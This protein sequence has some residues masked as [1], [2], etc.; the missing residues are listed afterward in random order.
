MSPLF[1]KSQHNFINHTCELKSAVV[2]Y[3][4]FFLKTCARNACKNCNIS[5]SKN[6]SKGNFQSIE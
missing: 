1:I 6:Y 2:R 3:L 4:T 5:Q